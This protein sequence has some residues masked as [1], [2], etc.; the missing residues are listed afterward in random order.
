MR[1]RSVFPLAALALAGCISCAT[2]AARSSTGSNASSSGGPV[3]AA[4]PTDESALSS[5]VDAYWKARQRKDL[6]AM[7]ELY[8][9]GYRQRHARDQFLKK[10]R[11]V[12]FDILDFAILKTEITGDAA[13]VTV[14][15]KTM[16]PP[17]LAE[18]FESRVTDRW[19]RDP[20]G[21]WSK[22]RETLL[23]P[24][25]TGGAPQEVED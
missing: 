5:R 3:A 16:A 8:S 14:S 10:T 23:L 20:D 17:K 7:Y 12:R 21:R 13:A 18:P 2:S 19:I 24:F 4:A 11:L 25:G 6:S 15:Y 22:E 1:I 9:A